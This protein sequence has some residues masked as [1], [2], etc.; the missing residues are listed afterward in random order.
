MYLKITILIGII[1]ILLVAHH[2][3]SQLSSL[4][5]KPT[6][7]PTPYP[8]PSYDPASYISPI[9]ISRGKTV[10]VSGENLVD[11]IQA[12]QD[13]PT[14]STVRIEGGGSISKELTLRKHTI[15]DGSTY[16]CDVRGIT[17]QGQ[18]LL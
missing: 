18:F 10:V 15:F 7:T 5:L 8:T 12:A 17:D 2:M 16:S 11:K 1:L 6:Q 4:A 14:V 9:S 3:A 13:D